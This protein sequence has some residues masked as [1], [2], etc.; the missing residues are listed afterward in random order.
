M[1]AVDRNA[2]GATQAVD[3]ALA[4]LACFSDAEPRLRVSD[5]ARR[6]GLSQST[7]SRLLATMEAH[8]FLERDSLS[9]AYLLGP[10]LISL[11]GIALNQSEIRRQAIGV[12]YDVT[13]RLGLAANLAVLREDAIFYVAS[14]DAPRAPKSFTMIGKRNPLHCTGVGKVLL[15]H[16]PDTEREVILARL[17]FPRFT[18]HTTGSVDELRPQLDQ[19]RQR[20]VALEREEMAFGRACIAAPVRD[21]GGTV[22]AA[23][24]LSGSLSALDLERREVELVRE[25]IETADQISH[26]LGYL[27]IPTEHVPISGGGRTIR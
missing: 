27:T 3:R 17:A 13:A 20:G 21:A 7:I 25:A 10:A 26:R 1:A 19:I 8:G 11:A 22:V 23:V 4:A 18:P 2:T 14:V 6:L 24:S 5:I 16:L 12:M 15:A 9:G